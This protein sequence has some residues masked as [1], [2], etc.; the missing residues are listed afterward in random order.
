MAEEVRNNQP[1][2]ETPKKELSELMQSHLDSIAGA[3]DSSHDSWRSA[4]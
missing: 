2:A 4:P 1:E 3:A